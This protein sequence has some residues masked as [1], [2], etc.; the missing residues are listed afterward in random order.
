MRTGTVVIEVSQPRGRLDVWLHRRFPCVSRAAIQR[1]LRE[2]QILVDGRVVKATHH[3]RAGE[4]VTIH[5]PDPKPPSVE[6]RAIPLDVIFEDEHLLVLNKPAGMVVH[7]AAGNEDNTL[8][9]ALLHHCRGS[10]SGVGGVERPGIVHRLDQFTSGVMVVAKHDA[11]HVA[12][13]RQFAQR[14]VVKV[15]DA[16]A[17]GEVQPPEGEVVAAIMRHP[18]HRKVMTV[19]EGGRTARTSY[20]VIERLGG[21]TLVEVRLHTG[22]THQV[23]V[24]FKHI[25]FP[26]VGDAVYGRKANVRLQE[27]TGVVAPRQMLHARRLAFVHPTLQEEVEFEAPWPEDFRETVRRLRRASGETG[28]T[29]PRSTEIQDA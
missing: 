28:Q 19:L 3:P 13:S 11:A 29:P 7:P 27:Q 16:I 23:R 18:N 26:L 4:V 5:W 8:V 15:Y 2:G 1:L 24:H 17:C 12:L 21:A 9:N 20:R 6:P 25:G 10:L 14:R 22:R